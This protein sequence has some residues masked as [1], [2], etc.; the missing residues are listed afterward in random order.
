MSDGFEFIFDD[1]L[2]WAAKLAAAPDIVENE[3]VTAV[4]RV[5]IAG[6]EVT[7]PETPWRTGHLR[8]SNQLSKTEWVGNGAVGGWFNETP[9]ALYVEEGTHNADGS[10]RMAA[11]P[12]M[13]PGMEAADEK[14]KEEFEGAIKRIVAALG[15]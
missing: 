6:L 1:A 15:G 14:A 9:Y 3:M 5:A 12:F 7:V 13:Q 10:E 8:R 11:Q 4:D 2:E